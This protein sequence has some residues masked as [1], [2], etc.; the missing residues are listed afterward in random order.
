MNKSEQNELTLVQF[1]GIR[2]IFISRDPI[3][4]RFFITCGK[5]KQSEIKYNINYNLYIM[6]CIIKGKYSFYIHGN[7]SAFTCKMRIISMR[8]KLHRSKK[9]KL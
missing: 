8:I 5:S 7:L 4:Q 9:R 3:Y 2:Q 6:I 1:E